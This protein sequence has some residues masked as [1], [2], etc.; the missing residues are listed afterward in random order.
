MEDFNRHQL[1]GEIVDHFR[2]GS[3][4]LLVPTKTWEKGGEFKGDKGEVSLPEGAK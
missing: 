1:T 3:I 2:V 4:M